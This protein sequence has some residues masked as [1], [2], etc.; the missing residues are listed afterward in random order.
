MKPCHS[1]A[2][3][4]GEEAMRAAP[5]RSTCSYESM[6][7]RIA[8]SAVSVRRSNCE[9]A[10]EE[11]LRSRPIQPAAVSASDAVSATHGMGE[12]KA[13]PAPSNPQRIALPQ[14]RSRGV[15]CPWRVHASK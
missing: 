4:E 1:C 10:S 7:E 12:R 11:R 6:R 8:A 15:D 14:G 2:V 9:R 13:S 5:E 3:I